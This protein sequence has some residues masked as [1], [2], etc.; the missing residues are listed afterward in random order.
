MCPPKEL[1]EVVLRLVLPQR[2]P[3]VPGSWAL[4]LGAAQHQGCLSPPLC[5]TFSQTI[6]FPQKQFVLISKSCPKTRG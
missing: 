2:P 5:N 6:L 1:R 3:P 4:L